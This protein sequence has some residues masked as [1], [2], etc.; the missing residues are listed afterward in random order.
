MRRTGRFNMSVCSNSEFPKTRRGRQRQRHKQ[1]LR[2]RPGLVYFMFRKLQI[3]FG[4]YFL[5]TLH[6]KAKAKK[7][8]V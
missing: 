3:M 8:Q 1:R 6:L 4:T 7:V 2:R 5:F